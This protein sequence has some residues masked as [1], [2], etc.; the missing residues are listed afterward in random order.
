MRNQKLGHSAMSI[1]LD[2]YIWRLIDTILSISITPVL[3][4]VREKQNINQRP[5]SCSCTHEHIA[6][7]N[8]LINLFFAMCALTAVTVGTIRVQKDKFFAPN[9]DRTRELQIFSLTLSQ[10]SY[11]SKKM[12][13]SPIV[14]FTI[15]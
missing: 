14:V 13:I 4:L 2:N 15:K 5:Q 3:L 11:R 8:V 12:K 7:T 1:P 6:S 9:V 10:L